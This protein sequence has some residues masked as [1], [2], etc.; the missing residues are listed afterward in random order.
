MSV[1]LLMHLVSISSFK[2]VIDVVQAKLRTLDGNKLKSSL[3]SSS[4]NNFLSKKTED[5]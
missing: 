4:V 1:Q 3:L 5:V 2:F